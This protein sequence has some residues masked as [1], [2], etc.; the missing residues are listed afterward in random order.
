[1]AVLNRLITS[2]MMTGPIRNR[3]YRTRNGVANSQPARLSLPAGRLTLMV[4]V[5][6]AGTVGA[7]AVVVMEVSCS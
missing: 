6:T 2:P 5:L 1:M 7:A 3:T 4:R